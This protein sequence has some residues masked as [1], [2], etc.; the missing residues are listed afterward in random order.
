MDNGQKTRAF[1]AATEPKVKREIL[2]NI[3]RHYG[4]AEADAEAEVTHH[5][6]EPLLDYV[7][8]P[9]RAAVSVLLQRHGLQQ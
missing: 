6:A 3:A 5:E 7:T 2:Q 9:M 8:G 1:F 4:I